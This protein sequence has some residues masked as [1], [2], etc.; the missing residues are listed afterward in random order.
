MTPSKQS[1]LI[2]AAVALSAKVAHADL[3]S[4]RAEAHVGAG[5]GIGLGG[6]RKDEAF[7]KGA[8]PGIYG[9]LIGLE[10]VFVDVW[11]QHDQLTNFDRISTWTQFFT[12]FDMQMDLGDDV[13][14]KGKSIKPKTFLEAGMGL[15]FGVGTGQQVDPPLNHS[16]ITDKAFLIEG[17]VGLGRRLSNSVDFGVRVPVSG[18]YFFKSGPGVAVNDE[19]N[20]YQAMEAAVLFFIRAQLKLK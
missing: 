16:Q 1:L 18:G 4:V 13:D 15:G 17:Q 14:S 5:G 12:G 11:V 7:F 20:H 9:A 8:P 6:D 3:I 2:L 19:S 10:I